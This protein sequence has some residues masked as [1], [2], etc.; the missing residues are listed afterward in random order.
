MT[1]TGDAHQLSSLIKKS[2][3]DEETYTSEIENIIKRD[4]FPD[5]PVLNQLIKLEKAIQTKDPE[6]IRIEQYNLRKVVE[7]KKQENDPKK[8]KQSLDEF[9]AKH[10]SEDNASFSILLNKMQEKQRERI[11]MYFD[12]SLP[13]TEQPLKIGKSNE[14]KMITSGGESS[15][16]G[17]KNT[18]MFLPEGKSMKEIVDPKMIPP[19]QIIHENTG[20]IITQ[21]QHQID[22]KLLQQQKQLDQIWDVDTSAEKL[23]M[24][25]PSSTPNIRGYKFVCTPSPAPGVKDSP[26]ITWG[27]IEGTPLRLDDTPDISEPKFKLPPTP[28]RELKAM[29][30]AEKA[31]KSLKKKQGMFTPKRYEPSTPKTPSYNRFT[32]LSPAAQRLIRKRKG[33]DS[34]AGQLR[35]SYQS[36]LVANV[37]MTPK[38]EEFIAPTPKRQKLSDS[39]SSSGSITDNLLKI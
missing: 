33:S 37:N 27:T 19:K 3:L 15:T 23:L 30:L 39:K 32:A 22:E 7:S 12:Y 8:R 31:A 17:K 29:E 38:P 20:P 18:L 14:V 5:I 1:K 10:T 36:P 4:F 13:S 35:A 24:G 28:K 11:K 34:F 6:L 9:L 2:V 16:I 25:N 26:I 21:T